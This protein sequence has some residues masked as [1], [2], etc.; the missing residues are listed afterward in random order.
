[1]SETQG[2]IYFIELHDAHFVK[3][4]HTISISETLSDHSE[5]LSDFRFIGFMPG[6]VARAH[7]IHEHFCCDRQAREWFLN[8]DE[9]K[10]FI[11]TLDLKT[12]DSDD[13]QTAIHMVHQ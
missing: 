4:S 10:E 5:S 8:T 11:A 9:L 12:D 1:M 3:I 13:G 2:Y 7:Q 6:T